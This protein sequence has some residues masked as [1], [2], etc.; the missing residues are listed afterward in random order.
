MSVL[1]IELLHHLR[2]NHTRASCVSDR[3]E[4][5]PRDGF[6]TVTI[7]SVT[8]DFPIASSHSAKRRLAN[9]RLAAVSLS[10]PCEVQR[11]TGLQRTANSRSKMT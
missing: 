2:E 10:L 4:P 8:E 5:I 6:S 9:S 3:Y 7:Q 1:I 11:A